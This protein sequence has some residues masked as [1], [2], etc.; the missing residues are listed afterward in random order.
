MVVC[1]CLESLLRARLWFARVV[2]AGAWWL[3]KQR[4]NVQAQWENQKRLDNVKKK[5]AAVKKVK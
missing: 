3:N 5:E 1:A 4:K 2:G